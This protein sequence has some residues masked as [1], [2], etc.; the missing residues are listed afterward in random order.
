MKH[1]LEFLAEREPQL[2]QWLAALHHEDRKKVTENVIPVF[3]EFGPPE[4]PKDDSNEESARYVLKAMQYAYG[5]LLKN[6]SRTP[7]RDLG[8][9]LGRRVSKGLVRFFSKIPGLYR[10]LMKR[11]GLRDYILPRLLD[12]FESVLNPAAGVVYRHYA[13]NEFRQLPDI[14]RFFDKDLWKGRQAF[15]EWLD[16]HFDPDA[17]SK[18]VAEFRKKQIEQVRTHLE[19]VQACPVRR[20]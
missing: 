9:A 11:P 6:V 13:Y 15:S 18:E 3:G 19:F 5:Q 10:A 14:A 4:E 17:F 20:L 16:E 7:Y 1:Y 2:H 8:K 12:P